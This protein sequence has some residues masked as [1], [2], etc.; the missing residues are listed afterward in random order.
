MSANLKKGHVNK[1]KLTDFV[2]A[3]LLDLYDFDSKT[4]RKDD[5]DKYIKAKHFNQA[6]QN[7]IV[8][9]LKNMSNQSFPVVNENPSN[10]SKRPFDDIKTF[11][12][13]CEKLMKK[14]KDFPLGAVVE[15]GTKK[16]MVDNKIRTKWLLAYI[17]K[18]N[19]CDRKLFDS[20]FSKEKLFL[21]VV[22]DHALEFMSRHR[23]KE[24]QLFQARFPSSNCIERVN[25]N[26]YEAGKDCGAAGHTDMVS[27]CTVIVALQGDVGVDGC[28]YLTKNRNKRNEADIR[29]ELRT[30][31]VLVFG[32]TFHSVEKFCRLK[33]RLTLQV[34]F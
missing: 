26:L 25:V 21:Q 22:Y 5:L 29:I 2:L 30:R 1:G 13:V 10:F 17:N 31:D 32:R 11:D 18:E 16:S 20:L 33:D 28:F 3:T 19:L 14:A 7:Q 4:I 34:F 12:N 15:E 24:L 27:F 6:K 9:V 8:R 23:E